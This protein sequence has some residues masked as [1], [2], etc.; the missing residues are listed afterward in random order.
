MPENCICSYFWN[1]ELRNKIN[2]ISRFKIFFS[3]ILLSWETVGTQI[4]L[5][6]IDPII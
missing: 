6:N 1:M 4:Y 2:I 3:V 5:R